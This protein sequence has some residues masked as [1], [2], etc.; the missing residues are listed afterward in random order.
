[1]PGQLKEVLFEFQRHGNIMRVVAIDPKSGQEVTMIADPRH[2]QD[3]IKKLAA[4]KLAYVLSKK[5]AKEQPAK[6]DPYKYL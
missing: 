2:S 1:M 3:S 4:R 5:Q 6:K